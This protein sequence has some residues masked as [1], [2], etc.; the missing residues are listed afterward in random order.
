MGETQLSER[1]TRVE[2]SIENIQS[3][4]SR[5]ESKL[6]VLNENLEKRF[7]PRSE[8]ESSHKRL[9]ERIDD[10]EVEIKELQIDIKELREKQGKL[11]SWAASLITALIAAVGFA[12]EFHK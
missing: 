11:P 10:C 12:V 6:D 5:L 2:T 4:L 3:S 1:I 8:I 7:V 9:H